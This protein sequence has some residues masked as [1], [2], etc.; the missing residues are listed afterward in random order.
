MKINI[1]Q[2]NVQLAQLCSMSSQQNLLI[3]NGIPFHS[4]DLIFKIPNAPALQ[5]MK[6]FNSKGSNEH[7]HEI[8]SSGGNG[9]TSD[10]IGFYFLCL[11]KAVAWENTVFIKLIWFLISLSFISFLL[12]EG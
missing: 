9:N 8:S 7:S 4:S 10:F 11:P 5:Q 2:A 6:K 1:P 3:E 12:T